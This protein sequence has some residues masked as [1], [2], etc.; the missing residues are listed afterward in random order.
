[1]RWFWSK[2]RSGI[3]T[4]VLP[5]VVILV[6]LQIGEAIWNAAG[7]FNEKII[8]TIFGHWLFLIFLLLLPFLAGFLMSWKG[9]REL[10][11][12]ICN[13][14]PIVSIFASY[15]F[16]KEDADRLAKGK[17]PEVIFEYVAGS[18]AI[19]QVM[20]EVM[21]PIYPGNPSGEKV[22]WLLIVGPATTPLS[23]TGQLILR[24]ECNVMYTGRFIKDTMLTVASLGLNLNLDPKKFSKEEPAA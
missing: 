23:V 16:N 8:G 11:L 6:V 17:F 21:L 15:L 10:G 24:R 20:N 9:F 5:M 22:K 18:W 4:A 7:Y 2:Y 14:I 13:K 19:G 3:L 1:M 12:R